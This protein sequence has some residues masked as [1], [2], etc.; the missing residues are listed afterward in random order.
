[1]Y[2][3]LSWQELGA[4]SKPILGFHL[5]LAKNWIILGFTIRVKHTLLGATGREHSAYNLLRASLV[6]GHLTQ[7]SRYWPR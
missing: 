7:W 4:D 2:R 1:M 6:I 3:N 5:T